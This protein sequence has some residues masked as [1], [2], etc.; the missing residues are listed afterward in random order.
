MVTTLNVNDMNAIQTID[1]VLAIICSEYNITTLVSAQTVCDK[2]ADK[3]P[4]LNSP[5][6][7]THLTRVTDELIEE[8]YIKK[9]SQQLVPALYIPT[10]KGLVYCA[11]GGYKSI[12]EKGKRQKRNQIVKDALL[13]GGAWS[14]AFGLFANALNIL[15]QK[16]VHWI[17]GIQF[18]S[19]FVVFLVGILIGIAIILAAKEVLPKFK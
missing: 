9:A 6:L 10:Y 11:N 4:E 8:G 17:V 16:G 7:S 15:F 1:D 18:F 12:L 3:Y 5:S 14:A 19:V 2:V 13:I